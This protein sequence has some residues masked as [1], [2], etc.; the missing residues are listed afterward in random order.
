MPSFSA[1]GNCP[2]LHAVPAPP[3]PRR[4]SMPCGASPGLLA[5]DRPSRMPR[6]KAAATSAMGR[7]GAGSAALCQLS[8]SSMRYS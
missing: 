8:C 6:T 2:T 3:R 7:S 1:M 4:T 5:Y